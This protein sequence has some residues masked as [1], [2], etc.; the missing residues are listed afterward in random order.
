MLDTVR[1]L[2]VISLFFLFAVI[3]VLTAILIYK[4]FFRK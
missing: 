2:S 1:I 4:R 3:V